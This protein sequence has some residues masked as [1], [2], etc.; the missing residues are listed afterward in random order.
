MKDKVDEIGVSHRH[1]SESVFIQPGRMCLPKY[2]ALEKRPYSKD[3]RQTHA[4]KCI[5]LISF[6]TTEGW[7]L[8]V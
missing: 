2:P 3:N 1:H 7:S 6:H 4:R 8:I 5:S